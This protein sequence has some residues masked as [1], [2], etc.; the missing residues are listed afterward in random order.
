ML[1]SSR[2][3]RGGGTVVSTT[4][5][6]AIA[7]PRQDR[8]RPH[9]KAHERQCMDSFTRSTTHHLSNPQYTPAAMIQATSYP[10]IVERVRCDAYG[11]ATHWYPADVNRDGYV[12]S[13]DHTAISRATAAIYESGY[14]PDDDL[15]RNGAVGSG[16]VAACADW[17]GHVPAGGAECRVSSYAPP[18]DLSGDG[19]IGGDLRPY[20]AIKVNE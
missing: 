5:L 2:P 12:N 11:R 3:S 8:V 6:R 19:S 20:M 17:D 4:T 1:C 18:R 14:D 10:L 7:P 9:P 15:A 16:D 13:S